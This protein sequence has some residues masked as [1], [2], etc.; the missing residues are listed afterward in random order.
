MVTHLNRTNMK[1]L[2]PKRVQA[3]Q[4]VQLQHER[5]QS[6][7]GL[8]EDEYK[9]EFFEYGMKFLEEF[10]ERKWLI[11]RAISS[12]RTYWKWWTTE[13]NRFELELLDFIDE[14][15]PIVTRKFWSDEMDSLVGDYL[16]EQGFYNHL[17]LFKDVRI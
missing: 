14:H 4:K 2:S 10:Y 9:M 13:W 11:I 16:T 17:K 7:I 15:E 3:I 1:T 6:L 5:M 12:D 8:T